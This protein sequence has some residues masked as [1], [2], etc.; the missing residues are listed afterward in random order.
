MATDRP[1]RVLVVVTSDQRRGGEIEG[2]GLARRLARRGVETRALALGASAGAGLDV[3]TLGASPLSV[4]TLI[5]LRRAAR[6]VDL[7]VAHGGSTLPA[8]A[9][10]LIAHQTPFVY[11][12]IGDPAAWVSSRA[13]RWRTGVLMRRA[14]ATVA[15]WPG[16]AQSLQTL[17]RP[18]STRVI[19]NPLAVTGATI[20]RGEARERFGLSPDVVVVAVVGALSPE[21]RVDRA[22]RAVGL[23][24]DAHLLVVGDGPRRA[25]VEALCAELMPG[26]ST[27]TGSLDSVDEV[28]V[29]ADVVLSTSAT[30][31]IPG[32]FL[33][34]RLSGCPVVATDVGGVRWALESLD[35]GIVLPVDSDESVTSAAVREAVRAGRVGPLP[36]GHAF[37]AGEV[38]R[39][40]IALIGE[41]S[42]R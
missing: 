18:R 32:V 38:D 10:A 1:R 23:L 19:P 5:A 15:L 12:S 37:D 14:R 29:A 13:H 20:S 35:G 2:L 25:A 21:K 36:D 41:V 17:Y 6:S 3:E 28:Y 9:L 31:G 27:F 39:Q 11:R 24:D 30:E 22:V 7:V 40:W 8:C 33:E 42:R 16:A 4:R 26:R 34:A